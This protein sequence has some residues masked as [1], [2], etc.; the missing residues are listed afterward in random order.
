MRSNNL[1]L[2]LYIGVILLL[3]IQ[4]TLCTDSCTFSSMTLQS[5]SVTPFSVMGP[6]SQDKTQSMKLNWTIATTICY[7]DTKWCFSP[8]KLY[9][10]MLRNLASQL[11]FN[12][13]ENVARISQRR[14]CYR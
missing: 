7:T 4:G 13:K 10:P 9:R 3:T 12:L 2:N 5:C 14:L 11:I 1:Q 6:I 8:S